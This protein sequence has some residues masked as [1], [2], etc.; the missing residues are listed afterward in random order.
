MTILTKRYK[1]PIP[2]LSLNNVDLV[3]TDS[4]IYLSVV[5]NNNFNDDGDT[6]RQLRC[7]YASSNTILRKF[8]YC[9]QKVKLYLL[10]SYCLNCG[11]TTPCQVFSKLR[12]TYNNVFHNL[13]GYGRRYSASSMFAIDIYE[14]WM[15][16]AY[17]TFY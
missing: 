14:A 15:H 1:L 8:T 3:Y 17:F 12:V 10:E 13:L 5:L 16:K 2:S 6:S 7:L 9:T 11:V 4:I